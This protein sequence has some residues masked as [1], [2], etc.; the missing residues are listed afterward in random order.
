M[1][2]ISSVLSALSF[3]LS[4][5]AVISVARTVTVV[6]ELRELLRRSPQSRIASLETSRDEMQL[7]L[8]NLANRLKMI[9]V[10]RAADHVRDDDDEKPKFPDPHR[11]PDGWRKAMNL[12]LAKRR[13]GGVSNP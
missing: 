4:V 8:L 2:D 5:V 12:D 1:T 7:E 3:I 9:K 10:R 11:D 6:Q 13:I